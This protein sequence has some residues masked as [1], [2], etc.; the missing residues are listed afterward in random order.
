MEEYV[1]NIETNYLY[2]TI[3]DNDVIKIEIKS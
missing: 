3:Y 2:S 1:Y